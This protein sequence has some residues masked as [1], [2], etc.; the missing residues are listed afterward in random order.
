MLGS[1]G[2][3]GTGQSDSSP[4]P[5][6]PQGNPGGLE[7]IEQSNHGFSVGQCVRYETGSGWTLARADSDK[8]LALGVVVAVKDSDNFTYSM[9]GRFAIT[10]G[11]STDTWYYLSADVA[12]ALTADIPQI[13]QPIVCT[14][15]SGHLSI[16]PYRPSDNRAGAGS[17]S[18][19]PIGPSGPQGPKGIPGPQGIQGP[20]GF[21]GQSGLDGEDGNATILQGSEDTAQDIFD[22][23][24]EDAESG[25]LWI[26]EETLDAWLW[27]DDGTPDGEWVNLGPIS[28][29]EGPQGIQGPQGDSITG[30][31]G[32]IGP[33]GI[34]GIQGPIGPDGPD[35]PDGPPG[36]DSIIAGPD[37][38]QGP[39]GPSGSLNLDG[40]KADSNYGGIP[41]LE[42]GN[43]GSF[44]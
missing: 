9:T 10:H 12:G 32:E 3:V 25:D 16:F 23:R 18:E 19:G 41:S 33:D 21:Q 14:D 11:L 20:R 31:Q 5:Q 30:E 38:E 13:E 6:G 22:K 7:D 29:P 24:T 35:G 2:V 15:D 26:D 34:Q 42:C 36:A 17:G 37:G 43:A 4:G 1:L 44:K 8:T 27:N 40:G 28:G 39:E